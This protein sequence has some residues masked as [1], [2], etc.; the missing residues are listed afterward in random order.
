MSALARRSL[1]VLW[2]LLLVTAIGVVYTSHLCR[3]LYT[4]LSALQQEESRLQ[5]EWG[6]YLLEQSTWAALSRIEK[7]ASGQLNMRVPDFND[8]IMVEP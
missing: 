1:L 5:V 6:Q 2:P 4:E 7:T 8:M 3:Q